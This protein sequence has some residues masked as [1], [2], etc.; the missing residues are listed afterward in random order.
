MRRVG[1]VLLQIAVATVALSVLG[2]IVGALI[3]HFVMHRSAALGA[4]WGIIIVGALTTLT[5]GG[6]GSPGE[7]LVQGRSGL[8]STYWG[9]SSPLPQSP[10]QVV[11]GGCLTV[12]VGIGFLYLFAY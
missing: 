1:V 2:G 12:V 5:A 9:Q 11:L 3:G 6:S 8:F 7:N 10:Y 4:G